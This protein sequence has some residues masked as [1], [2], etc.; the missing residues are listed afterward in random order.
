MPDRATHA[1]LTPPTSGD[2][3]QA[4]YRPDPSPP[5]HAPRWFLRALADE[6]A[7]GQV[8]VAGARVRYLRWP[9][10]PG[11]ATLLVHGGS[12]HAHWWSPLAPLL[13]S[14]GPVVAMDL[15][16]HGLSDWRPGGYTVA[17]WAQE[18]RA[19]ALATSAEPPTVIAHSMGGIVS[20]HLAVTAGDV[21]RRLIVADSPVWETAPA[22]EGEITARAKAP[23]RYCA[24]PEDPI[25]RFRLIPRQECHN[26]WYLRHI[27]WHGL[28]ETPEG[29]RWRFDPHI[30][31]GNGGVA[32]GEN[33]IAR[34]EGSLA[35]SACPYALVMGEDSYL[36]SDALKVFGPDAG[37]SAVRSRHGEAPLV[38]VPSAAH[39]IMLDQPLAFVTAIRGILA[40]WQ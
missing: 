1:Q 30:F 15:S 4:R 40:A 10:G 18:V 8:E 31:S 7:I 37:S 27:A 12:A 2:L 5:A 20:A 38:L 3:V 21:M 35:D 36:A 22:P 9:G 16:G 32:G 17:Q 34:F 13:R 28:V 25:S 26:D 24:D 39:H 23:V 33:R 11:P 19:V 6:P 14:R 29:Y